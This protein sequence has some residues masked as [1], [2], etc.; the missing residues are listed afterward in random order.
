MI[1]L[2]KPS[3]SK[4]Y[5]FWLE[6]FGAPLNFVSKASALPVLTWSQPFQQKGKWKKKKAESQSQVRRKF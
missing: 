1:F 6:S 4:N 2:K 5:L 3:A